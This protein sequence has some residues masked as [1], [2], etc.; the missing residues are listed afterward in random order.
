MAESVA[1]IAAR[2]TFK[3]EKEGEH[4]GISFICETQC[5]CSCVMDVFAHGKNT[6]TV[7]CHTGAKVQMRTAPNKL[8]IHVLKWYVMR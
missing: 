3:R 4:C 8:T 6:P 1:H 7:W 2:Q 5:A